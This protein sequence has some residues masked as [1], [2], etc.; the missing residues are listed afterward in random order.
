MT[1]SSSIHEAH[2]V[3][4][5]AQVKPAYTVEEAAV[6][7]RMGEGPLGDIL[8][9]LRG[10]SSTEREPVDHAALVTYMSAREHWVRRDEGRSEL[11]HRVAM[12]LG[13]EFKER[14]YEDDPE[15]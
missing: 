3:R 12:S 9:D 5:V 11:L 10:P 13:E 7:L 1:G 6:I 4:R 2:W 8:D 14:D 15:Y